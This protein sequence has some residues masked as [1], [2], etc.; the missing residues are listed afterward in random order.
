MREFL[1]SRGWETLW[2][3]DYWIKTEWWKD[4]SKNVDTCGYSTKAA[5]EKELNGV[6]CSKGAICT[7]N[8]DEK[9]SISLHSTNLI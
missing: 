5:Y 1:L 2:S 4:P 3:E 9:D 8:A 6:P 7:C